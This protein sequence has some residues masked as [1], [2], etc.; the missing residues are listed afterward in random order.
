MVNGDPA[1]AGNAFG[2]VP[3]AD[4]P[5]SSRALLAHPS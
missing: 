2:L 1:P 5:G 4:Y 3:A